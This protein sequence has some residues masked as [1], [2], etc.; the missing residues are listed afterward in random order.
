MVWS[1]FSYRG[2]IELQVVQGC[3]TAAGYVNMLQNASMMTEGPRLCGDGWL[4]QQDNA[5]I[6]RA[7]H[8]LTFLQENRVNLLRQSE[9][10]PE[11]NPIENIWGQMARDVYR[12]GKQYL[13][14]N[15]LHEA[16]FRS[17]SN[18]PKELIETLISSMPQRIF[19]VINNIGDRTH[20]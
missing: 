20:Y 9:C 13:T 11:M 5:A 15:E 2:T 7:R 6:H 4:F 1:A 8:T 19:E 12:N 18:I 16:I 10:S 17:W 3:Q 14:K